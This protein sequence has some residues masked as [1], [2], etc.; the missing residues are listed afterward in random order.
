M[1]KTGNFSPSPPTTRIDL[2]RSSS[3]SPDAQNG[4]RIPLTCSQEAL[5]AM[6]S[7]PNPSPPPLRRV[8]SPPKESSASP[9]HA[10]VAKQIIS[11]PLSP[12]PR[13]ADKVPDS[14]LTLRCQ[15]INRSDTLCNPSPAIQQLHFPEASSH[16]A[17]PRNRYNNVLPTSRDLVP[18]MHQTSKETAYINASWFENMIITQGPFIRGDVDTV[19]DFW[20]LAFEQGSDIVCLTDPYVQKSRWEI[21]EKT[22]PYWE[23]RLANRIPDPSQPEIVFKKNVGPEGLEVNL[24]VRLVEEPLIAVEANQQKE[25]VVKRTFEIKFG[26]HF[27]RI[28]HWYFENWKDHSICQP[29]QLAHLIELLLEKPGQPIVHCSA[30]IGRAGV[31]AIVRKFVLLYKETGKIPTD[32]E[33]DDAIIDLRKRRP[34]SVQNREQLLLISDTIAAFIK[35]QAEKK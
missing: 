22:F 6:N 13:K 8:P 25:K 15:R 29:E 12:R 28:T 9:K 33:I 21:D 34:G 27:K 17:K 31:F 10:A 32:D 35:R 5:M 18:L 24:E 4:D 1:H 20:M 26:E 2:S 16:H 23:P 7:S 11:S 30:G 3:S 14:P 19:A